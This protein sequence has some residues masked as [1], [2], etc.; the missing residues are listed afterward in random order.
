[1]PLL[2]KIITFV[3]ILLFAGYAGGISIS[4]HLCKGKVVAKA[5]NREV[6]VCNKAK[7]STTPFTENTSY[8]EK[9]CCD[10]EVDFFQSDTFSKGKTALQ[11]VALFKPLPVTDKLV[12]IAPVILFRALPAPPLLHNAPVYKA[13]ERY[14]I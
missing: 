14:L 10:T 11:T 9:S 5:V 12:R 13:I 1:M 6:K 2:K 4:K 7:S 3:L 8:S